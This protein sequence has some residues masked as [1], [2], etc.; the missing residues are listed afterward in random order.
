MSSWFVDQIT[1]DEDT[2]ADFEVRPVGS[3][4]IKLHAF[5]ELAGIGAFKD[6][7]MRELVLNLK[8]ADRLKPGDRP[9]GDE[10]Q[11]CGCRRRDS[12]FNQFH[13]SLGDQYEHLAMR[14]SS[15]VLA[16]VMAV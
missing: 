7:V 8:G 16:G 1:P 11:F 14:M 15:L 4:A 3:V 5:S 2:I 9:V 10:F 6:F 13:L 12:S